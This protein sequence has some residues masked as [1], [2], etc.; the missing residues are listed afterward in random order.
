VTG[1]SVYAFAIDIGDNVFS[2]DE[3]VEIY[4]QDA[5]TGQ[6]TFLKQFKASEL[7]PFMGILSPIPLTKVMYNES[8]D[9]DDIFVQNFRFGILK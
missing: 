9:G 3:Y 4:G 7:K 5:N 1:S 8:T 2:S 6:E